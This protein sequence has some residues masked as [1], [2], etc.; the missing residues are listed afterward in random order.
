MTNHASILT[1]LAGC[2]ALFAPLVADADCVPK[3][4]PP[5]LVDVG[6]DG[7]AKLSVDTVR[8]CEGEVLRWNFVGPDGK[9]MAVA[10]VSAQGSPFEWDRQT[11]RSITGTV[12]AGAAKNQPETRYEYVVE[13]DGQPMDPVIIIE[14]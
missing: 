9:A 11:G 6:A 14:R 2:A 13:I 4:N 8:A 1:G 5:I 10:F 3:A 7:K 12:K